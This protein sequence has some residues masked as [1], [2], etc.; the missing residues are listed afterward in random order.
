MT[1]VAFVDRHAAA[2][3]IGEDERDAELPTDFEACVLLGGEDFA[4]QNIEGVAGDLFA[5]AGHDITGDAEHRRQA[6]HEVDVAGAVLAGGEEHR[7]NLHGFFKCVIA[8]DGWS[9][10]L[11]QWRGREFGRDVRQGGDARRAARGR[12]SHVCGHGV[13][14]LFLH[15]RP[16]TVHNVLQVAFVAGGWSF[17]E[18]GRHSPDH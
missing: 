13:A 4:N 9:R 7:T 8:D 5:F 12:G 18:P 6:G 14:G 1:A 17:P 15:S 2:A 11:E 16:F 10:V 3:A